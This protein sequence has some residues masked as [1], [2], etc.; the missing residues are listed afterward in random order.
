[1]YSL[2]KLAQKKLFVELFQGSALLLGLR[3]VMLVLSLMN[4]IGLVVVLNMLQEELEIGTVFYASF[5]LGLC[6]LLIMKDFVP[7]FQ[8]IVLFEAGFLPLRTIHKAILW[9]I[10]NEFSFFNLAVVLNLTLLLFSPYF[11]IQ[12]LLAAMLSIVIAIQGSFLL[13]F[14]LD[15]RFPRKIG[16]SLWSL[17]MLFFFMGLNWLCFKQGLAFHWYLLGLA[18]NVI[19]LALP[20]IW[21]FHLQPKE[22]RTYTTYQP[23]TLSKTLGSSTIPAKLIH[24]M[25]FGLGFKTLLLFFNFFQLYQKQTYLFN[26]ELL[27]A[28][29]FAPTTLFTYGFNNYHAFSPNLFY[30]IQLRT[31]ATGPFISLYFRSVGLFCCLDLLITLGLL[32]FFRDLLRWQDLL[33]FYFVGLSFLLVTGLLGSLLLP[34]K[35]EKKSFM[36]NLKMF[37]HPIVSIVSLLGVVL[38][39]HFRAYFLLS[40]GTLALLASGLGYYLYW[41]LS[42]IKYQLLSIITPK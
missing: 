27:F 11:Q 20:M 38:A 36:S 29:V 10:G 2:F 18:G 12:H 31:G 3:W 33:P 37:T 9:L 24:S 41:R 26:T 21:V 35:I 1:M 28:L 25:F 5:N 15:Y 8:K 34:V 14:H 13:R 17:L 32:L 30:N 7:S 42:A 23:R 19:G 39:Y 4:A 16:T 22:Y 6:F 40:L